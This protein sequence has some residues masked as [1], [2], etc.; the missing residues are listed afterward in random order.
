MSQMSFWIYVPPPTF[1]NDHTSGAICI[2][3]FHTDRSP[4]R[5]GHSANGKYVDGSAVPSMPAVTNDLIKYGYEIPN[6]NHSTHVFFFHSLGYHSVSQFYTS[7]LIRCVSPVWPWVLCICIWSDQT[8]VNVPLYRSIKNKLV[9]CGKW[10][11]IDAKKRS[12]VIS[13]EKVVIVPTAVR[14]THCVS[15]AMTLSKWRRSANENI[16]VDAIKYFRSAYLFIDI[17]IKPTRL[18]H[19]YE[20]GAWANEWNRNPFFIL[21]Q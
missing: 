9:E 21:F 20:C 13:N 16:A 10:N 6:G 17:C 18:A 2:F 4:N 11:A 8:V 1:P 19:R 5:G 3:V 15:I 7:K 12:S 14:Q